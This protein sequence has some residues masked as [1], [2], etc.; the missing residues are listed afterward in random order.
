MTQARTDP[1][2]AHGVG[3]TRAYGSLTCATEGTTSRHGCHIRPVSP[4]AALS[5]IGDAGVPPLRTFQHLF[6]PGL[7]IVEPGDAGLFFSTCACRIDPW[8]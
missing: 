2:D 6:P 7:D 1:I 3:L 8:S 5:E 4:F